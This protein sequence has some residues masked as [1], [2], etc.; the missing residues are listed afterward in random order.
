MIRLVAYLL[1]MVIVLAACT[2]SAPSDQSIQTAIAQTEASQPKAS[3]TTTPTKTPEPSSTSTETR[4]PTTTFT[5]EPTSTPTSTPSPTP[6]LRVIDADP[7]DFLLERSDLPEEARYYLPNAG[8]ISPHRNSEV[9]S[10]WGVDEGREYLEKTGRIDGWWVWYKRGTITVIAPEEIYD[11]IVIYQSIE[12]AQLVMTD[13]SN[14]QGRLADSDWTILETDLQIGDMTIVCTD[15]EMQSTGDN[16]VWIRIEFTYRNFYH[17][18]V[19]WG[20]EKEVQL[21][22]VANVARILLAKLEAAPLSDKVTFS[23]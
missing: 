9:V 6:D 23:P 10:G 17:A 22:Y 7:K 15:K 20:W 18:V 3:E 5:P 19:G 1:A 4:A 12:G 13:Y 11:N 8:W 2:P 21:E 16:R 14:C